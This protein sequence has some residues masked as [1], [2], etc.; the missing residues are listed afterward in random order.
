[1]YVIAEKQRMNGPMLYRLD[2]D[3]NVG[4]V[5][6]SDLNGVIQKMVS[7]VRDDLPEGDVTVLGYRDGRLYCRQGE[8]LTEVEIPEVK[9][10]Q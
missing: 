6:V 3:A 10:A 7:V 4:E 8:V 2:A 1:M 9:N 5:W